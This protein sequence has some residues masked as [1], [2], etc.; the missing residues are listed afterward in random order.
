ML[1]HPSFA[2]D[3]LTLSN[4]TGHPAFVA[5]CGFRDDGTP[6]SITF[7]G[8]LHDE[9]RLLAAVRAWQAATTYHA[10]HP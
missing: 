9:T 5:P 6:Y 3:V 10:R 7:T 4:L 1:V 8:R 2:G